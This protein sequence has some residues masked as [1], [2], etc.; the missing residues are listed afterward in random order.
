MDRGSW[1]SSG[2][3]ASVDRRLRQRHALDIHDGV[4]Q[5]IATAKLSLELGNFE[6]GMTALEESLHAARRIMTDLLGD[7]DSG[8]ALGPGDLRRTPPT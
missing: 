2:G 1:T 5:K 8:I 4:V 7:R 3:D 6:L